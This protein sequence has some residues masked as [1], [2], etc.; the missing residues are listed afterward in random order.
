M[1]TRAFISLFLLS[2][3]SVGAPA[4]STEFDAEHFVNTKCVACHD[5]TVYTRENRRVKSLQRLESQV[6]MCD[7]NLGTT[8]FDKDLHAVVDYLNDNYYKFEK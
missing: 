6:R 5:S 8:L 1:N 7:A 3:L 2:A 4:E